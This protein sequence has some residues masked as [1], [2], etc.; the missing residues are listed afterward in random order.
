MATVFTVVGA[1]REDP[2]RLLPLGDDGQHYAYLSP[3]GGPTRVDPNEDGW[4]RDPR[5]V[6]AAQLGL[7]SRA[8]PLAPRMATGTIRPPRVAYP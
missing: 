4:V 8:R 3:G 6:P 7:G 1:H 2:G 5:A